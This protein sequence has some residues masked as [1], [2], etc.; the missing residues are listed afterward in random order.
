ME[1]SSAS[2]RRDHSNQRAKTDALAKLP[3]NL[4][5]RAKVEW[6]GKIVRKPPSRDAQLTPK[7]SVV[8]QSDGTLLVRIT[9]PNCCFPAYR[10]DGKPSE[11]RTLLPD[12]PIAKGLPAK[13]ELSHTEMYD[14]PFHVPAP[15]EV[16]FEE[17][18][19]G[20]ER[21]RSGAIWKVGKGRLFYFRPGHETHAVYTEA[22]PMRVVENA[23]R[24]LGGN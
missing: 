12:H 10:N 6:I 22:L 23:V 1:T 8:K 4:R 24:W 19:A 18:W 14:E 9:R 3:E 21:F 2:A 7:A 11:I 5:K 15:D 20:G 17:H 16:V 13:F